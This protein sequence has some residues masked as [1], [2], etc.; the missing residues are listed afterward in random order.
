[1][2]QSKG[3]NGSYPAV[4]LYLLKPNVTRTCLHICYFVLLLFQ[5]HPGVVTQPTMEVYQMA[6]EN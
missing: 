6:E 3:G 1:M 4:L 5:V 2:S